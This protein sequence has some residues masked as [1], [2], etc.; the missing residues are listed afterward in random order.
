LNPASFTAAI[1]IAG[2]RSTFTSN[3]LFGSAKS[4]DQSS[5]AINVLSFAPIAATHPPHFAF[6]LNFIVAIAVTIYDL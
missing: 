4:I 2:A 5:E 6:V 3:T 1:T